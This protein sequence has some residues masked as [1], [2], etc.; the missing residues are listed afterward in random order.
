MSLSRRPI[1]EIGDLP[2]TIA[3][4]PL[5]GVLLL[6]HG[7]LPLNIFEPRY[8]AMTDD[9]MKTD[10]RLIGMIQPTEPEREGASQKLHRIGC[11][12][13]IVSI[14]ETEDRRYLITLAGLCRFAISQEL[15]TTRGYRCVAPDFTA[16]ADDLK[17]ASAPI[18][19]R[20]R[21]MAALRGFFAHHEIKADWNSIEQAPDDRLIV[22]LA[23]VCPFEPA[24]K[25]ALLEA[26]TLADRVRTMIALL[27][28]AAA[29]VDSGPRH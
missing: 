17:D 11:A 2:R 7:R 16:F 9:A 12:G 28:L 8:L 27:E 25:Q 1:R 10:H 6:P 24:E 5:T 20:P 23:M 21:L 4:F 26:P 3:V 18:A 15:D 13:R 19:D 29:G 22:T 14:S